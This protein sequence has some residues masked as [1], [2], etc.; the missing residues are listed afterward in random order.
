MGKAIRMENSL[1]DL[2]KR[3]HPYRGQSC[4]LRDGQET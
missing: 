1:K 3:H 4:L 2:S